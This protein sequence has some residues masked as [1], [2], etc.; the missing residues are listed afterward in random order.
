ME[1]TLAKAMKGEVTWENYSITNEF[2]H[3]SSHPLDLNK[4]TVSHGVIE[5]IDFGKFCS[6]QGVL[7]GLNLVLKVE[8]GGSVGWSF[9]SMRDI[10][11]LFNQAKATH[12][13]DLVG[14][15]MLLLFTDGGGPGSHILAC[16]VN[17]SLVTGKENT[18][19]A[20]KVSFFTGMSKQLL[21][22]RTAKHSPKNT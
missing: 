19:V 5:N 1:I 13:K 15:P 10:Q 11:I 7:V 3:Y 2:W 6:Y 17:T 14:T 20:D 4:G 22:K 16:K 8:N 12:L 18:L 9:E 21:E